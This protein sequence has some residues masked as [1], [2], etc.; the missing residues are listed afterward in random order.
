MDNFFHVHTIDQVFDLIPD[1][2]RVDTETVFIEEALDRV[3]AT[4]IAA[5]EDLPDFS[6]A[7]MDGYAVRAASTFGATES[8][9]GLLT[10]TGSI[11]MGQKPDFSIGIGEAARIA[12]GG[13]LPEGADAVVMIEYTDPMDDDAIE[14]YKSV[15][16]GT[17]VVGVGEDFSRND[18][19]ISA[20]KRL[21]PQEIGLLAAF[22]FQTAPVYRKPRIGIISTGDEIVPIHEDP[23]PGKIRDINTHTLS[24]LVASAGAIPVSFGLVADHFEALQ[25]TCIRALQEMDMVLVSGGSSVG[26]RDFTIQA[27]SA[28]PDSHILIH[29]IAISPGKPTILARCGNRAFWGLPGH[30]VSAMVVFL[31]IVKPWIDHIAGMTQ[32][33]SA[34]WAI[35]AVLTRNVPSVHG[36]TDY[37]RVRLFERDDTRW[38]EPI[39]GKSGLI[40]TMVK[41]HGLIEIGMN[42]EGLNQGTVVNVEL[43]S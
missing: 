43:F 33:V 8:N 34:R 17:H 20:G 12:T 32:Q 2:P 16:P 42:T 14:V 15:A 24:G 27:L 3:L 1:F 28:I 26:T 29:G 40:N 7:T 31:K 11:G 25:Q 23:K 39:L 9:P 35:P 37:I 10:V 4:D 21:R 18:I 36:R 5:P 38:A 13:M 6:R 41:S 30:V 19:L 22:G